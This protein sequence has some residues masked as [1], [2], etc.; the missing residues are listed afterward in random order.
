LNLAKAN[1]LRHDPERADGNRVLDDYSSKV[2][3]S[4]ELCQSA[5]YSW[6]AAHQLY[7]KIALC[8]RGNSVIEA[9]AARSHFHHE[10]A[11][12]MPKTA[13]PD[14]LINDGK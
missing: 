6:P 5:K 14:H 12:D 7:A 13:L 10:S 1:H 4:S 8:D 3:R 9:Y 2:R 11:A